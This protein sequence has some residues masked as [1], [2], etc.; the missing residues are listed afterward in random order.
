LDNGNL[1]KIRL[2]ARVGILLAALGVL[3]GVIVAM[4]FTSADGSGLFSSAGRS[5]SDALGWAAW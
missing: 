3:S 2:P 1:R 5:L 4:G